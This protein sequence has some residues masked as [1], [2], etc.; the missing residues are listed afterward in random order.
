M[1][2]ED[3]LPLV[4]QMAAALQAAHEAGVVHR[5][6]KS[7]NVMLIPP[8]SSEAVP[9]VVVTDFGLA[10]HDDPDSDDTLTRSGHLVGTPAYMAPEQI[11][12]GEM[13][14]PRRAS[15]SRASTRCGRA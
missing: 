1:R 7:A 12:G 3:A 8:R 9:R 2:P 11:E 6:F 10:R 15:T 4:A 5:D 14:P 13:T